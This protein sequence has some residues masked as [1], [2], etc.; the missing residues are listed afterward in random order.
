MSKRKEEQ[1]VPERI[2]R[3][4]DDEVYGKIIEMLGGDRLRVECDDGTERMARIP[5]RFKKAVWVRMKDIVII[6]PWVIQGDKK[7]DIVWRYTRAQVDFLLRQ[8][9]FKHIRP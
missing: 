4:K 2:K 6:K 8:N 7:A 5:G 9:A 1:D 3:P